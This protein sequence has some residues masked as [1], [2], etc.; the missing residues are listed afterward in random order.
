MC[1]CGWHTV[2]SWTE[3]GSSLDII[4][5]LITYLQ[6]IMFFLTENMRATM[7]VMPPILLCWLITS[8]EDIGDMTVEGEPSYQHSI[9]F[10]CHATDGSSRE[11]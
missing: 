2:S 8:E 5:S 10:D 11:V 3:Y 9:T 1:H 6:Y 4:V 7:K